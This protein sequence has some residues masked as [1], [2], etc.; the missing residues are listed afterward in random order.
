MQQIPHA[1]SWRSTRLLIRDPHRMISKICQT[2]GFDLFETRLLF[3]RTICLTGREAAE[4]FYDPTRFLRQGATPGRLQKTLFGQG[5]V[6]GLDGIEHQH[7]KQMFLS[8]VT[9]ERVADLVQTTRKYWQ[10][11]LKDGTNKEQIELYGQLQK[12]LCL[13]VCEWAGVSL[14]DSEVEQRTSQ[15]T[16]LFDYAGTVG[17]KNWLARLARKQANHWIE[18]Y[19]HQIRS[20]RIKPPE[21]SAAQIIAWHR[22]LQ[23]EFLSL[24]TAA[25]E[26]LN[27]LRPV[28]AVSV[29]LVFVAHALHQFPETRENLRGADDE[30][31]EAFV[32]EVR[33]FYPFFPFV[34]ACARTEF[35]WQGFRIPTGQRVLFDL[36]GTNHDRRIWNRPDEF[37]P[38]RFLDRELGPYSFVPQG[39]G[40]H[41]EN[42]RCPGEGIAIELMKLAVRFF[43]HE[44]DYEF[45]PQNLE[46]QWSRLPPVPKNGLIL[47]KVKAS[48]REIQNPAHPAASMA[49]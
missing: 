31:V 30:H 7:R 6:Q 48:S 3:K 32:Q 38:E 19:I 1:S 37:R 22:N 28:I 42:H 15:L 14:D 27:V 8:L 49:E 34:A 40:N 43:T 23:D 47:A 21:G 13:A 24:H 35:E 45:P 5:G 10:Q 20:G 29:Y 36:Y 9:S 26:L 12:I 17:P 16:K 11:S 4:V 44:M 41:E 46:L 18:D 25:V 39:G 33:R 2:Q